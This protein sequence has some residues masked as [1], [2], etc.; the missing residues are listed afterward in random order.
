MKK[1]GKKPRL[2]RG[3]IPPPVQVHEDKKKEGNKKKCRKPVK[4]FEEE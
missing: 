2:P 4:T 1:K 3:R